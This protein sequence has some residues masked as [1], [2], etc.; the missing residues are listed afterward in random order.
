MALRKNKTVIGII[1]MYPAKSPASKEFN[2]NINSTIVEPNKTMHKKLKLFT[3]NVY[4]DIKQ[5]VSKLKN[6]LSKFQNF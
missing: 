4:K 3:K 6:Y 2:S 1:N 5:I